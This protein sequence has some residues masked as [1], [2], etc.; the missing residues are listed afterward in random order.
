MNDARADETT[1]I[2]RRLENWFVNE[3]RSSASFSEDERTRFDYLKRKVDRSHEMFVDMG[4]IRTSKS[5][6]ADIITGTIPYT[7]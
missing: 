5:G 4:I 2:E 7:G 1:L 3:F 6:N